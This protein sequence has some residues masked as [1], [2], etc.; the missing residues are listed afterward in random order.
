M[1][2][3]RLIDRA[4]GGLL[5]ALMACAALYVGLIMVAII[6]QT[7]FRTLGW[8][9]SPM[10]FVFIEYGFVYALFLG[11]PWLVR[12]RGHIYIEILTAALGPRARTILSRFLMVLC[13]GICFVWA[14]YGAG[15]LVETDAFSS[16]AELMGQVWISPPNVPVPSG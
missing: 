13:A 11:S 9:Y 6:Y 15:L 3:L 1:Y 5:W 12:Q 4:W 8:D 10:A 7:V 14:W 2:A 16:A